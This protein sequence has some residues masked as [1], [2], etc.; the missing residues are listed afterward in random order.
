[1]RAHG[2]PST[3]RACATK[4]LVPAPASTRPKPETCW[5]RT[6]RCNST[7]T[8][9]YPTTRAATAQRQ[10]NVSANSPPANCPADMPRMVPV[11]KRAS[12]ACRRS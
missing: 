12:V 6:S 11:R 4:P 2:V 10:P 8:A 1:M 3:R 9:R 5:R 7:P